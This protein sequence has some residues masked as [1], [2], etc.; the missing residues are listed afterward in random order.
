MT[1][2]PI[3]QCKFVTRIKDDA[4]D[5][6]TIDENLLTSSKEKVKKETKLLTAAI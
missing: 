6:V 4:Y 5:L 2:Y 1:Q 3:E